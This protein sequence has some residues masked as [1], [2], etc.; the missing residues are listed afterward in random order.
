LHGYLNIGTGTVRCLTADSGRII[1]IAYEE[2]FDNGCKFTSNFTATVT[3]QTAD[4]FMVSFFL[5]AASRCC[6]P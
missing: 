2:T 6:Y 4:Q 3:A 1:K 5:D